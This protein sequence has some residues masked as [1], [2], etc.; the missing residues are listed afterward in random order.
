MTPTT[1]ELHASGAFTEESMCQRVFSF[2]NIKKLAGLIAIVATTVISI[3][4]SIFSCISFSIGLISSIILSAVAVVSAIILLLLLISAARSK[5]SKED[6]QTSNDLLREEL[7]FLRLVNQGLSLDISTIQFQLRELKDSNAQMK[8]KLI[9]LFR[10][11]HQSENTP[12]GT[13]TESRSTLDRIKE[14]FYKAE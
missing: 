14:L 11:V 7:S 6:L 9:A 4:L 8:E 10:A 12:S 3:S 2:D 1:A 13:T 5:Q